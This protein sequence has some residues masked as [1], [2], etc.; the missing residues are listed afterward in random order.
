MVNVEPWKSGLIDISFDRKF[1][2]LLNSYFLELIKKEDSSLGLGT[3][4]LGTTYVHVLLK[5]HL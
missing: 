1:R 5:I 4:I 2:V 3:F